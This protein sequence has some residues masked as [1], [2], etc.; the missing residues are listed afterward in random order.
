MWSRFPPGPS[1]QAPTRPSGSTAT[2]STRR[3]TVTPSRESAAGTTASARAGRSRWIASSSRARSSP[4]PSTGH[5]WTPPAI[6]CPMSTPRPGAATGWS[7]L[8]SAPAGTR[9]PEE[10]PPPGR[11]NHPVVMVSH[12]DATA[13]A[14]WLSA[15]TG[16]AW[17]LPTALEWEKAARGPD[18]LV[19]PWG[20]TYDPALLNSHDAGPFDTL[21]VGSFP[22]GASPYGMLD[23]A[24]QVFEWT[25]SPGNPGRFLVKGGSWDDSGCGV[26]R[27]AARHARPRGHQA[28]TRGLPPRPRSG[29]G[30]VAR[31][32]S[33]GGRRSGKSRSAALSFAGGMA[34]ERAVGRQ[35]GPGHGEEEPAAGGRPATSTWRRSRRSGCA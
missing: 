31:R 11:E 23:A 21:P 10:R 33:G 3:P 13:F 24:G 28:H 5:S 27:P 9:G 4:T 32:R 22:A 29:R 8:T 20:D 34:S 14:A 2:S 30:G 35:D 25:A 26:C 7:T 16:H 18:G 1:S 17:R 19:F 6:A 15:E 12:D